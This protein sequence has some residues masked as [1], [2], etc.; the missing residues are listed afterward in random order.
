MR[1]REFQ[2]VKLG[3]LSEQMI[4]R[5]NRSSKPLESAIRLFRKIAT[6]LLK[7]DNRQK[8]N[9]F[10]DAVDRT[11]NPRHFDFSKSYPNSFKKDLI[12]IR[13]RLDLD[14]ESDRL[15]KDHKR[16]YQILSLAQN[17]QT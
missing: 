6:E 12:V 2:G 7:Y 11:L 14:Y 5:S 15:V 16:F 8:S 10:F 9:A 13:D 4:L 17:Q 1:K 3:S